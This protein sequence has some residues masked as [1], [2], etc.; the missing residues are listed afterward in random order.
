MMIDHELDNIQDL[1]DR[2]DQLKAIR[3]AAALNLLE[4]QEGVSR[5]ITDLKK[6]SEH[7]S[8]IRGNPTNGKI[9]NELAGQIV[10]MSEEVGSSLRQLENKTLSELAWLR[11][12]YQNVYLAL[13]V[14]GSSLLVLGKFGNWLKENR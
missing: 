14:T 12:Q 13:F 7:F 2:S 3:V 9:H 11:S 8:A 1:S 6:K 4:T 10:G 5:S